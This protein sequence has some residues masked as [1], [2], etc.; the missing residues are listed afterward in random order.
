MAAVD[1]LSGSRE[2]E[3][4]DGIDETVRDDI[5]EGED[6]DVAKFDA[7]FEVDVVVKLEVVDALL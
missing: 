4:A 2:E 6:A 3:E 1:D 5:I 7:E